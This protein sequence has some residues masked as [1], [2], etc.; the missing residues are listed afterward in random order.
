MMS[1]CFMLL[2]DGL[3]RQDVD[4]EEQRTQHRALRKADVQVDRYGPNAINDDILH[5]L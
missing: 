5:P 2:D 3:K 1:D 4:E